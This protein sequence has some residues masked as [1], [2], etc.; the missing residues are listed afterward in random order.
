ME[1]GPQVCAGHTSRGFDGYHSLSRHA[2]PVRYRRL[3]NADFPGELS[4]TACRVDGMTKSRIAQVD[5]PSLV[6]TRLLLNN[7]KIDL[8]TE[9]VN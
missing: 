7:S 3:C 4:Y 6:P 1:I 2:G 8:A 9:P 5:L